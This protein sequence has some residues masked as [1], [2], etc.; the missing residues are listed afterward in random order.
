LGRCILRTVS[1]NRALVRYCRDWNV[2]DEIR[3]APPYFLSVATFAVHVRFGSYADIS[4]HRKCQW[5]TWSDLFNHLVCKRNQCRRESQ[6]E[7]FGGLEVEDQL[8]FGRL[9][10]RKVGRFDASEN[11]AGENAD[12]MI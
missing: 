6:A 12:P 4:C 3:T 8:D 5:R 2:R 10:D 7:R 11:S 1:N 9:L